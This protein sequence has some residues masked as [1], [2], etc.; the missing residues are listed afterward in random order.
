MSDIE[1]TV[2]HTLTE[3]ELNDLKLR[4]RNEISAEFQQKLNDVEKHKKNDVLIEQK[5]QQR[6]QRLKEI[7]TPEAIQARLEEAKIL[8]NC[9]G[10]Q[11]HEIYP[12]LLTAEEKGLLKS[13]CLN[14]GGLNIIQNKISYSAKMIAFL[15]INNKHEIRV[16]EST[17][18]LCTVEI[19]RRHPFVYS[20][21]STFTMQDAVRQGLLKNPMWQKCPKDMLRA[22][23][24]TR[25]ASEVIPE[26]MLGV[27]G[28]FEITDD[29]TAA[30][31]ENAFS[32]IEFVL[33]KKSYS[34]DNIVQLTPDISENDVRKY[35]DAWIEYYSNANGTNADKTAWDLLQQ[36]KNTS[37][38]FESGIKKWLDKQSKKTAA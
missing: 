16:I 21:Q 32:K 29:E 31:P 28:D 14:P 23:A 2:V 35:C 10:K 12:I 13:D 36:R 24:T 17:D 5:N 9:Y 18:E 11:P 25:A 6:L 7:S 26:V 22:R 15:I 20:R 19:T 37:D 3:S 8:A 27:V 4:I 34:V 1:Q 38:A 33:P 30:K